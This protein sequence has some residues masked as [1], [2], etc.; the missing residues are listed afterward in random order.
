MEQP[1]NSR[2]FKRGTCACESLAITA[3]AQS[4]ARSNQIKS[5]QSKPKSQIKY[6]SIKSRFSHFL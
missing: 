1:G 3:K 5:F 4:V 2:I 6:K